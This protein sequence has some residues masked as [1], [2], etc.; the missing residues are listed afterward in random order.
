MGMGR[1]NLS[2][3]WGDRTGSAAAEMA[4]VAP[5]LITLMFGSFEL[6]RYFLDEHVV[7]KAVRDGA[8]Y[9]GRLKFAEYAGCGASG[10]ALTNVQNLTRTGQVTSGGTARLPYWTNPATITVTVECKTGY[11]GIYKGLALDS[12]VV[13]VSAT[14]P[15]S[16]LFSGIG[17][18]VTGLNIMASA[19][20]AVMGI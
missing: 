17:F 20:S 6:G 13:T 2:S 10:A 3:L 19:E 15:Y 7:V 8:R 11:S 18:S 12:P 14:V 4:L 16:S 5:L 9:A 1:L